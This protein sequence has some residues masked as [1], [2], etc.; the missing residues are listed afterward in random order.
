M[1][2]LDND[3]KKLAIEVLNDYHN[4]T[5]LK[6]DVYEYIEEKWLAPKLI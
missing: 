3:Q 2:E 1:K 5:D 4:W 6:T